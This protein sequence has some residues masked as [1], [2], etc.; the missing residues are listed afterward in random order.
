MVKEVKALLTV[1]KALGK[2]S[3]KLTLT[4]AINISNSGVAELSRRTRKAMMHK[5]RQLMEDAQ[6]DNDN[7][8]IDSDHDKTVDENSDGDRS[9]YGNAARR[10]S[11][12][13]YKRT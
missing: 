2:G 3:L 6:V 11:R 12:D 5:Y 4:T 7:V 13:T 1:V 8:L 9:A 10:A